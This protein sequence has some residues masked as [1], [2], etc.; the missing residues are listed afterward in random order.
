MAGNILWEGVKATAGMIG[1]AAVETGMKG[2]LQ[3]ELALIKREVE[4]RKRSFGEELYGFV[5][6]VNKMLI[7]YSY[8]SFSI[9]VLLSFLRSLC[10]RI[11]IFT[12]QM[13]G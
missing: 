6:R 12:L 13:T 1:Q 3:T 11:R 5:V 10:P 2:K 7:L 4:Q 9:C 8:S